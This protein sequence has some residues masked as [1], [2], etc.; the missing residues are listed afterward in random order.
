MRYHHDDDG[1][2]G[3]G[4]AALAAASTALPPL[5]RPA[6]T[7]TS[8]KHHIFLFSERLNYCVELVVCCQ[9]RCGVTSYDATSASETTLVLFNGVPMEMCFTCLFCNSRFELEEAWLD[10]A[11]AQHTEPEP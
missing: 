5:P 11:T 7:S 8:D 1:G 3:G 6:A 4:G 2:G 10:Q 9:L